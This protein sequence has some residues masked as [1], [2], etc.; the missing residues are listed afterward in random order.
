[1][2]YCHTSNVVNKSGS[3]LKLHQVLD[4]W[5]GASKTCV[6]DPQMD[7]KTEIATKITQN[8]GISFA[9]HEQNFVDPRLMFCANVSH[10]MWGNFL[11]KSRQQVHVQ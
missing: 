11:S 6:L 5:T 3:K 8:S 7:R 10:K 9:F 2:L 1:M 4:C